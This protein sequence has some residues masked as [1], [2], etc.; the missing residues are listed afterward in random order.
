MKGLG[1]EG[2]VVHSVRFTMPR[3]WL[4]VGIA[5]T[6]RPRDPAVCRIG[7]AST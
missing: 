7:L 1:D 2:G 3:E 6:K 4:D 5:C